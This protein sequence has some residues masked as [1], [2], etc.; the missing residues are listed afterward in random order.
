MS[1]LQD[2]QSALEETLDILETEDNQNERDKH[3]A[4]AE[5]LFEQ[6]DNSYT[7]CKGIVSRINKFSS[8]NL[9]VRA[10]PQN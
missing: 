4:R 8:G 2:I 10:F 5:T 6:V 3:I 1:H 9:S 7:L